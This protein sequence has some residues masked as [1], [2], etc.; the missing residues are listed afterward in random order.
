MRTKNECGENTETKDLSKRGAPNRER[1]V[2]ETLG[3]GIHFEMAKRV[4]SISSDETRTPQN[5]LK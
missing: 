1:G 5:D 2:L 3:I 4:L